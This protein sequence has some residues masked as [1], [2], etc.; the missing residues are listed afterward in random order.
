ML[1]ANPYGTYVTL[2]TPLLWLDSLDSIVLF[3]L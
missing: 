3:C 1:A 2:L